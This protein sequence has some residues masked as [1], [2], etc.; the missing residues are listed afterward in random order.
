MYFIGI[1]IVVVG[2]LVIRKITGDTSS[3]SFF[4]LELPE[5][6]FPSIKRAFI[7]M[8]SQ[9]KQFVIKAVT[10]ILISNTWVP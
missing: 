5:Y 8:I 10:I 1:M 6:R 2:A 4:I 9:G 3:R 7:S